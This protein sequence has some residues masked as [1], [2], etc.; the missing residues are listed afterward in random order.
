M[1]SE[2]YYYIK[3]SDGES[4]H[5]CGTELGSWIVDGPR[6]DGTFPSIGALAQAVGNHRYEKQMYDDPVEVVL[7]DGVLVVDAG[8]GELFRIR[9]SDVKDEWERKV[10]SH[11]KAT[12]FM[13]IVAQDGLLWGSWFC[14]ERAQDPGDEN[15]V[16]EDL[17][18]SSSE[19]DA[20]L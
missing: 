3:T 7:V 12:Q 9:P 4:F 1:L 20:R 10:L 11:P 18:L 14:K 19:L 2:S 13:R 5:I 8:D 6:H 16:P 17:L 15:R